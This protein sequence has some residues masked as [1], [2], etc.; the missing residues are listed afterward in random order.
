MRVLMRVSVTTLDGNHGFQSGKLQKI[1]ADFQKQYQPEMLYYTVE[2]GDRVIYVVVQLTDSTQLPALSEP[3]MQ[4]LNAQVDVTP[5]L[6][7]SDLEDAGPDIAM[8]IG[9][10]AD[11][12]IRKS[13]HS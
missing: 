8:A 4:G 10:Y 7:Y 5:C 13:D 9:N 2:R 1:T 11:P 3:W 12:Y 6:T